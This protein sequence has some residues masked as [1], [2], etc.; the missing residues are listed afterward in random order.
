MSPKLKPL[1]LPQLVE[2]QP[3]MDDHHANLED[4][5]LPYT[6]YTTNSSSSDIVSPV[7]PTFSARTHFR[8]SSSTSSLDLSYTLSSQEAPSPQQPQQQQPQ[9]QLSRKPSKRQ[10]PDV[11]EEP[12]ERDDDKTEHK[13]VVHTHLGLYSCLCK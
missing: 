4:E 10:L 2:R 11:E 5:Q 13:P 6:S 7:T 1:L 12:I 8:G 9:P 3:K